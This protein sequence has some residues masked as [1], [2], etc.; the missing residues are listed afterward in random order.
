M[1]HSG[2]PTW[3]WNI[4]NFDRKYIFKGSVF[5]CYV[6]L[7]ECSQIGNLPQI[8]GENNLK[9]ETT[10]RFLFVWCLCWKDFCQKNIKEPEGNHQ[11]VFGR[12][13]LG[14]FGKNSHSELCHLGIWCQIGQSVKIPLSFWFRRQC[15][16]IKGE[17]FVI[18]IA[19]QPSPR[20]KRNP[21]PW[22]MT[23]QPGCFCGFSSS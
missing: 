21:S 4:P 5:H 6:S 11:M 8:R 1:L 7:P 19:M 2:K 12:F 22:L 9:N 10:P 16:V 14:V 23:C 15:F 17:I 18:G 20:K 3:Q 13:F